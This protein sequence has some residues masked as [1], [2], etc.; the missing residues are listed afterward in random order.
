MRYVRLRTTL[1]IFIGLIGPIEC[2]SDEAPQALPPK[3]DVD[4]AAGRWHSVEMVPGPHK[5]KIRARDKWN[6]VWWF[7]N[8]DEPKPPESY[9]P[10]DKHRNFKWQLRN[11]FHNFTFFVIGVAD[12]KT[13]RSGRYPKEA[14]KPQGGWNLA[15]TKDKFLRL[16]FIAY[17]RGKKGFHFYCGWRPRGNFGFKCNFE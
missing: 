4:E 7:K 6:P 14:F 8:S 11:P 5:S 10:H 15:V 16:P 13:V 1:L 3:K 2:R 17:S 9:R 12:K